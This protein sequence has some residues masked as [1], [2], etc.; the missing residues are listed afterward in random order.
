MRL[1]KSFHN[2][3]SSFHLG[4]QFWLSF[5]M[6]LL[7]VFLVPPFQKP[8]EPLHYFKSVAVSY[9]KL[10]CND[11]EI[12]LPQF[13]RSLVGSVGEQNIPLNYDSKYDSLAIKSGSAQRSLQQDE[14]LYP[15]AF[16]SLPT[17]GYLLPGSA[18]LVGRLI[19]LSDVSLYYF[20]RF[21][22]YLIAMIILASIAKK[23]PEYERNILHIVGLTPMLQHQLSGYSYDAS[24]ILLA[25]LFLSQSIVMWQKKSKDITFQQWLL[26]AII[27]ILLIASKSMAYSP[28]ILIGAVVLFSRLGGSK[29]S[30]ISRML[31][32][33]V[34]LLVVGGLAWIVT[35]AF[36]SNT[37]FP[38][39]SNLV[40]SN[41]LRFI[42]VFANT[43]NSYHEFF[44]S[45]TIGM[46]GWLDYR[47]TF[48][49]LVLYIGYVVSF[50]FTFS[51]PKRYKPLILWM[52]VFIVGAITMAI[53]AGMYQ[54]WTPA[55]AGR[56]EGVQ[57]RYFLAFLPLLI[58]VLQ[59]GIQWS[60]NNRIL[61][62]IIAIAVLGMLIKD[63]TRRYYWDRG[64]NATARQE[65][66]LQI[67]DL[68]E[69]IIENES[70]RSLQG[71]VIES[72]DD[73]SDLLSDFQ[74]LDASCRRQLIAGQLVWQASPSAG[75]AV[76][77]DISAEP[78]Y[79]L[80]LDAKNIEIKSIRGL[81]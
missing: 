78:R 66:E 44:I 46:F 11:G 64:A 43:I 2:L 53:F 29:G 74:L 42:L 70:G 59:A 55:G 73:D 61:Q 25:I 27:G 51:L 8:D 26:L 32:S 38:V 13:Y 36:G 65:E 9:G 33:S 5:A 28:L 75:V 14:V 47:L 60:H 1:L 34:F 48:G 37:E 10:Q 41:P 3:L 72:L 12:Y 45:S 71:I 6:G 18:L 50:I 81:Y 67:S 7:F 30:W 56:I 76:F 77:D 20:G 19:G 63:I 79:C 22:P 16:C 62:I 54:Y 31:V 39:A 15:E 58:I 17:I 49:L 69:I 57:G 23:L 80:R 24:H 52:L 21:L 35:N 4:W 40:S 68:G